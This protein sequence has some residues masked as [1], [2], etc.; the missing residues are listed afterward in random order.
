MSF[1]GLRSVLVP[2]ACLAMFCLSACTA[3]QVYDSGQ[4]WQ[5]NQCNRIPDKTEYDGCMSKAKT[6]YE[7]YKRA[8]EPAR[9]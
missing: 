7:S 3:E 8:T 5:Q 4:A 6:T 1:N 9:K 2:A